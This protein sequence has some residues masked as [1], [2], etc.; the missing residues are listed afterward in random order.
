MNEQPTGEF[1]GK[2]LRDYLQDAKYW[3]KK[4]V[5]ESSQL[6]T[7]CRIIS[8]EHPLF[9]AD[10][11]SR[12]QAYNSLVPENQ[13]LFCT[14]F[15]EKDFLRRTKIIEDN[16]FLQCVFMH[17]NIMGEGQFVSDK[18]DYYVLLMK[19]LEDKEVFLDLSNRITFDSE[20]SA[21]KETEPLKIR[22]QC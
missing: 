6:Y 15:E 12:G 10:L 16:T 18:Y 9:Q 8:G 13:M 11:V 7:P 21:Y 22:E 3:G 20:K 5:S 17:R 4:F 19:H 2:K 14:D 1:R